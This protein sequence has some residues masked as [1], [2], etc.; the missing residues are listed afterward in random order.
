MIRY[1]VYFE[2]RLPF[3]IMG[4]FSTHIQ[5][6]EGASE[7]GKSPSLFG[8]PAWFWGSAVNGQS[9]PQFGL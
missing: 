5:V 4:E 7:H 1:D 2:H 8:S 9:E 3:P 6:R